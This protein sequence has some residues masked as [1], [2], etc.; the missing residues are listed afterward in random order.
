M[1]FIHGDKYIDIFTGRDTRYTICDVSEASQFVAYM[2]DKKRFARHATDRDIWLLA[3]Q[4]IRYGRFKGHPE[5][6]FQ[7]HVLPYPVDIDQECLM[8]CFDMGITFLTEENDIVKSITPKTITEL[9]ISGTIYDDDYVT[10]YGG[11]KTL[12]ISKTSNITLDSLLS[13]KH[14]LAKSLEILDCSSSNVIGRNLQ[15]LQNIKILDV[16]NNKNLTLE[17]MTK[18]HPLA[19]TIEVLNA[20]GTNISST[21]VSYMQHLK[22]LHTNRR[23]AFWF[24]SD[25]P[26]HP[27]TNLRELY[28]VGPKIDDMILKHMRR[29]HVLHLINAEPTH[30][31]TL[32]FITPFHPLAQMLTEL[33]APNS[34]ITDEGLRYLQ[35]LRTLDLSGNRVVKL[36]FV[37]D[38]HP[39]TIW[40]RT[41]RLNNTNIDDTPL[42][43]MKELE[44]LEVDNVKNVTLSFVKR[45]HPLYKS[46]TQITCHNSG[47]TDATWSSIMDR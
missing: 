5:K 26:S 11:L 40:L 38:G 22:V 8:E 34:A 24:V 10:G 37:R 19:H 23:M 29:L 12:V 9:N 43:H 18:D 28:C 3:E 16:S 14:P 6:I 13:G 1:R 15:Y 35:S 20:R 27:I 44:T 39:L 21:S 42:S 30:S 25:D 17:F 45:G 47:V 33:V 46:L 7:G 41:L 32:N 2:T 4:M 36:S 31:V